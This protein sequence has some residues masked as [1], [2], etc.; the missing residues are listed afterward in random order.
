MTPKLTIDVGHFSSSESLQ[1]GLAAVLGFPGWYG[2]NWDAFRDCV[3]HSD[4]SDMPSVLVIRGCEILAERLPRD[5][6]LLREILEE[7]MTRR[8]ECSVQW[9]VVDEDKIQ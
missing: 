9:E 5:A 3:T 6:R 7:M 8:P 4:I 1:E 2:R